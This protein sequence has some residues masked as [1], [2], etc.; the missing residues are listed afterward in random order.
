M[1]EID[2]SRNIISNST[3]QNSIKKNNAKIS[4]QSQAIKFSVNKVAKKR[5]LT[6]SSKKITTNL[7][8]PEKHLKNHVNSRVKRDNDKLDN[9]L[10]K[11]TQAGDYDYWLSQEDIADI[12]RLRYQRFQTLV[13]YD[14]HFEIIGSFSQLKKI[15]KRFLERI[16][17]RI[18]FSNVSSGTVLTLIIHQPSNHWTSLV[19]YRERLENHN[20]GIYLDSN[21]Q[22]LSKDY[23]NFFSKNNIEIIDLTKYFTQQ[24][25][26]CNCGL[27]ALENA[28]DI[29]M[30][31]HSQQDHFWAL[32]E[33]K[34]PRD[35]T[36]FDALRREIAETLVSDLDWRN[37]HPHYE[38]TSSP[39]F[40][41]SLSNPSSRTSPESEPEN[42][43]FKVLDR[44]EIFVET[45]VMSFSHRL[46]AY[47]IIAREGKIT[48]EALR[49]ELLAGATGCLLGMAFSQC[50]VGNCFGALPSIVA[51]TRAISGKLLIKKKS[52]QRITKC[53][54]GLKGGSLS[55]ILSQVAYSIFSSFEYQF[56]GITDKGG[57]RVAMEKLADDAIDRIFNYIKQQKLTGVAMSNELLEKAVL[58]GPSD[59]SFEPSLRL[60]QLKIKGKSLVNDRIE[61]IENVVLIHSSKLFENVGLCAF[62][63]QKQVKK[64][65]VAKKYPEKYGYRR[66]RS[67]WRFKRQLIDQIFTG[68]PHI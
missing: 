55:A 30:M 16:N 20:I 61:S 34:R 4:Y 26:G 2:S 38:E 5:K 29:N 3:E 53:F 48:M 43:R 64:F 50:V 1:S 46:A 57:N 45:F 58:Q 7:S 17:A 33:I 24:Q 47:H 22:I 67:K 37:R 19:I 25:D 13:N 52:A 15:V 41:S 63:T 12:A 65:Y 39:E 27:W 11:A 68:F 51:S 10:V 8:V 18:A 66:K 54:D 62:D 14:N 44:K 36:Y 31:L 35:R 6:S 23:Q 32:N 49:A 9:N 42:K 56:T 28:A 21:G 40:S 59:L 60:L